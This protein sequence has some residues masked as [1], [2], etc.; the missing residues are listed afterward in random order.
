MFLIEYIVIESLNRIVRLCKFAVS[1]KTALYVLR[2]D[3]FNESAVAVGRGRA[4]THLG[5]AVTSTYAKIH[6]QNSVFRSSR[7]VRRVPSELYHS[8]PLMNITAKIIHHRHNTIPVP[9]C[10]H[11]CGILLWYNQTLYLWCE[12][13]CFADRSLDCLGFCLAETQIICF[14]VENVSDLV[15]HTYCSLK[16]YIIIYYLFMKVGLKAVGMEINRR[17]WEIYMPTLIII[18][19]K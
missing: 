1:T 13:T 19:S 4:P 9:L 11:V 7:R 8:A 14:T 17:D 6:Y 18:E 15:I 12:V 10:V 2:S 16:K 3:T 5:F